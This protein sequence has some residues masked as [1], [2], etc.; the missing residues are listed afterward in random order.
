MGALALVLGVVG[1]FAVAALLYVS[2]CVY[3]EMGR[4]LVRP[5]FLVRR[6]LMWRLA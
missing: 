4:A 1:L 3:R 6:Q 2:G 5:V